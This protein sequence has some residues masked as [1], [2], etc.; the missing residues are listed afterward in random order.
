MSA[1]ER[2]K[3]SETAGAIA[4]GKPVDW[5][6][7][8]HED[9]PLTAT[10]EELRA[11][12]EVAAAHRAGRTP[13]IGAGTDS[14]QEAPRWG[15]FRLLEPLGGGN[16]GEVWRAFDP[17]LQ[18]DVAL[19]L[20]RLA[21]GE[22]AASLSATSDPR[23]RRWLEEARRLAS[24]RHGN[25]LTVF[26][27]SEHEGRAGIWTELVRGETLETGLARNGPMSAREAAAIGRDLCAALGAVH[28]AGLV[29]GDV[30]TSNVMIEDEANGGAARVVLMDFGTAHRR[31]GVTT[32]S[33]SSAG[34]PL[35]MAPELLAGAG[36]SV[37]GDLYAAG[38]LIYRLLTGRY[39]VEAESLEE[40]RARH[41]RSERVGLAAARP[42]LPS[43][44]TR[45]V[46]RA[47]DAD[48]AR[49]PA[50][51]AEMQRELIAFLAPLRSRSARVAFAVAG[52]LGPVAVLALILL[53]QQLAMKDS[54][55]FVAPPAP[56]LAMSQSPTWVTPTDPR[57]QDVGSVFTSRSDLT[58]DRVADLLVADQGFAGTVGDQGRAMIWS[59]SRSGLGPAPG[60]EVIGEKAG[61]HLGWAAA[62]GDLSG[63]GRADLV[64]ADRSEGPVPG[65]P[66]GALR[67][68]LGSAHGLPNVPAQTLPGDEPS[69]SFAQVV[70]FAGDVNH[71]GYGD[72]VASEH[73]WN[74]A[75]RNQGRVRVYLGSAAGLRQPP[76]QLLVGDP[77]S[78]AFGYGIARAG[79][80]NGD[81]I[82]DLIVGAP[83][84]RDRRG[85]VGA[86]HVY[87]GGRD[88]LRPA[89]RFRITGDRNGDLMGAAIAC[90]GDVNGDGRSDIAVGLEGY[91]G[92]GENVGE[93]R[94]YL[95]SKDGLEAHPA[96]RV[97]GFGSYC[98]LGQSIAETADVDGDGVADLAVG[99][100]GY[101]DSPDA[102]GSGAVFL[103]RGA[104]RHGLFDR[105]P[106]WWTWIR[107]T[108]AL[109]GSKV[110]LADL[111]GDGL[112]DM[113][114]CAPRWRNG[115]VQEGR[116]FVFNGARR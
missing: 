79:D 53:R 2:S 62:G 68:F 64:L 30:K 34:T 46:E 83:W 50:S 25:V 81:G 116:V 97:R 10:L 38:V 96:W 99:G 16:F 102:T 113:I 19:K 15:P 13:S 37:A 26:G 86:I 108:E 92:E 11:I 77:Q 115:S 17:D 100:Y 94:I 60:W 32:L 85:E 12:G 44:L 8:S 43:R 9:G 98:Y 29:H 56:I 67:V 78:S 73:N 7:L 61:T 40:L 27:T 66:V 5:S 45:I 21:P 36:P 1:D 90:V 110:E 49:R 42:G 48:P 70:A 109:F 69:P 72:V 57:H 6:A 65:R 74:G 82:D 95:G 59:G 84:W 106:I 112:A 41:L 104:G 3:L 111:N 14:E 24:V 20:R 75:H 54:R 22:D 47:L 63:D 87:V 18:R 103:F 58:G 31:A 89:P 71:D 35:V 105:R 107:Q 88:A 55:H 39:P 80:L 51:A 93:V 114:V 23:T 91:D 101:G 76:A 4:D 28:G 52:M 33:F